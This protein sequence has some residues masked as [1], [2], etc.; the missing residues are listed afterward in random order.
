[1]KTVS[2]LGIHLIVSDCQRECSLLRGNRLNMLE[3]IVG[4]HG[5]EGV[6]SSTISLVQKVGLHSCAM[7]RRARSR[8][9]HK[10]ANLLFCKLEFAQKTTRMR[11]RTDL[12]V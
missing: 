8:L 5:R 4:T 7:V 12:Q 1:M 10:L 6:N 11:K 9:P 2:L 3:G